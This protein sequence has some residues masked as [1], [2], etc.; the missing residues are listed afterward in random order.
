MNHS[1][2]RMKINCFELLTNLKCGVKSKNE[3]LMAQ[4]TDKYGEF[5]NS[6]KVN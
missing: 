1:T 3:K 6:V 4:A 2:L 5:V